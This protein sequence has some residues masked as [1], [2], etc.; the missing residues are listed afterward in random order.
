M[1]QN[2][3]WPL[4]GCGVGL[5]SKHYPV[6]TSEWPEMEWFEATTENYMD[7]GGRPFHILEQVRARYPVALH[8]VSLSI[9]STD[10]LHPI[11][12]EHLKALVERIDPFIVSDHLC[13]AGVGGKNLHDLLPLPFTEE[14]IEHIAR[15]VQQ[16]Q[17]LL[18]RRILLEN[19]SSYVTYRHSTLPEWEFLR[20]VAVRSGC[21]ILLDI[22]NIYVNAYNH[23]FDAREYLRNIP[24]QFVG[25]FHL[26][27]HTDMGDFLFDTHSKPV[28]D[29]VWELY[30]EALGQYGQVNTL[31][32][33][34]EDIPEW[35]ELSKEAAHARAIYGKYLNAKPRQSSFQ[36]NHDSGSSSPND[37]VGD[38]KTKTAQGFPAK[39]SGND[40][41]LSLSEIQKE[42]HSLIGPGEDPSRS[43]EIPLNPQAGVPGKERVSVYAHGYYARI[44]EALAEVY[45]AVKHVLGEKMFSDLARAYAERYPS[46]EYNL[47][48]TGKH[49]S[50]F[51]KDP[52]VA[53]EMPFLSGLAALEWRGSL[54]F[55]AYEGKPLE[56][57]ALSRITPEDWEKANLV[58]QPSVSILNSEWPVFDIWKARDEPVENIKI[59]MIN[60][61]Q[62]VLIFRRGL[63]VHCA[64]L[65]PAQYQML[66]GLLA[67]ETLGRVCEALGEAFTAELPEVSNWFSA[68]VGL[69]LLTACEIPQK[70]THP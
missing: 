6:I 58:F 49:F 57:A 27:G 11:Y 18:G 67:G 69:G 65:D 29:P 1:N 55:H 45:A 61:S 47:T 17:E 4:L 41:R 19:V 42:F 38:Q 15:R 40:K 31:I 48:Q 68:W 2:K 46:A 36:P 64:L 33:W 54:A 39:A 32:E 14:A 59:D 28:I 3:N 51:L 9:G 26:A 34:D 7:S 8:G 60:R 16:V 20:E 24:S 52:G 63:E 22:N 56:T 44:A 13:W 30:R 50:E 43:K 25:Q 35:A 5:R 53:K 62:N 12:L 10:P 70:N 21:G 37:F 66:K 23:Q